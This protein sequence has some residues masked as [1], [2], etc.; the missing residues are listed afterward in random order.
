MKNITIGLLRK[1]SKLIAAQHYY[2]E[3]G[4]GDEYAFGRTPAEALARLEQRETALIPKFDR[5]LAETITFLALGAADFLREE[6]GVNLNRHGGYMGFLNDVVCVAPLL[7]QRWS[8]MDSS[9][10]P[11]VWLY[12]VVERFGYEWAKVVF[13]EDDKYPEILLDQIIATEMGSL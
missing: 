1:E 3:R 13:E 10:F 5:N 12:D 8:Q 7:E 11:G 4:E 6:Q 9:E 2:A